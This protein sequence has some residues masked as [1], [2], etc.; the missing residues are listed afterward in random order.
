MGI[1]YWSIY[2]TTVY[3]ALDSPQTHLCVPSLSLTCSTFIDTYPANESNKLCP[4]KGKAP[5]LW[6]PTPITGIDESISFQ[7][8]DGLCQPDSI[9]GITPANG[10][11]TGPNKVQVHSV[12]ASFKLF[13][14]TIPIHYATSWNRTD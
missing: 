10:T 2:L 4:Y 7:I 6:T 5:E 13:Y 3:P 11:E 12:L 14:E 9:L 1:I 8:S